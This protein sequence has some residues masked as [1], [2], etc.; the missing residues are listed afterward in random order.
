MDVNVNGHDPGGLVDRTV[1]RWANCRIVCGDD[2]GHQVSNCQRSWHA[3]DPG[4]KAPTRAEGALARANW[5]C[6]G[7]SFQHRRSTTHQDPRL[8]ASGSVII[9]SQCRLCRLLSTSRRPGEP[10]RRRQKAGCVHHQGFQARVTTSIEI[11]RSEPKAGT[12]LHLALSRADQLCTSPI[13]TLH[14][15]T[16][17]HY[18]HY[19]RYGGPPRRSTVDGCSSN[20]ALVFGLEEQ[21]ARDGS[22]LC[23]IES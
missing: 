19:S 13:G 11:T 2:R 3:G 17:P 21:S 6:T 23:P 7:V 9:D 14:G 8:D 15:A 18:L 12:S 10:E 4:P 22:A 20:G 16:L 1:A 5:A